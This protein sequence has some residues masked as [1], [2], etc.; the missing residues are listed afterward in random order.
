METLIS[1]L[2]S[3]TQV[4]KDKYVERTKQYATSE[5][6]RLEKLRNLNK[7][8][9]GHLEMGLE[10]NEKGTD[11]LPLP[12]GVNPCNDKISVTLNNL[13]SKIRSSVNMGIEKFVSKEENLAV[14][15]YN[16]SIVKLAKRISR[17]DLDLNNLEMNTVCMDVNIETF[18][19]DGN[20]T[21]KAWTVIA[22]GCV[23]RPHYRYL[24]K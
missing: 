1:N 17:K 16:N 15:H 21:V 19:T 24:I 5:F 22:G 2:K 14:K 11:F 9:I 18:I 13:I 6:K 23:Q 4:L 10:L 20:K 8:Q 7:F 12:N 3:Q